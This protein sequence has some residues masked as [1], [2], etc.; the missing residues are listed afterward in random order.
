MKL[1]V[2]D[3][4]RGELRAPK[5]TGEA[6]HQ[7]HA[8]ARTSKSLGKH[9]QHFAQPALNGA[10]WSGRNDML[11]RRPI[12]ISLSSGSRRG[13]T[14]PAATC[15]WQIPARPWVSELTFQPPAARAVRYALMMVRVGRK[16]VFV[17]FGAPSLK[18][19]PLDCVRRTI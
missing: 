3:I 15:W 1:N 10:F 4:E 12:R 16:R 14:C 18:P 5:A 7:Q 2:V 13:D 8:V 19:A 11:L 9:L 17:V 6:G